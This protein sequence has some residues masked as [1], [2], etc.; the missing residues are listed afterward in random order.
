MRSPVA[1]DGTPCRA[2]TRNVCIQGACVVSYQSSHIQILKD[3]FKKIHFPKFFKLVLQSHTL[4]NVGETKVV[5]LLTPT[6]LV[7]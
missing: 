7:L 6:I 1:V 4:Y 2:G 5:L 3:G